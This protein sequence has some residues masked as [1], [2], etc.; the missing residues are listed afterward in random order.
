MEDIWKI[1]AVKKKNLS[2]QN[3][4]C[5]HSR[6]LANYHFAHNI[7]MYMHTENTSSQ[8]HLKYNEVSITG[9]H[10]LQQSLVTFLQPA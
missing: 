6:K 4:L 5:I 9:R 8:I 3:I 2:H 1:N 7:F 10:R